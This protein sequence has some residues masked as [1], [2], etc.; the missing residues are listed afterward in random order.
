MRGSPG[1]PGPPPGL[2]SSRATVSHLALVRLAN[3][4]HD[5]RKLL[6]RCELDFDVP[7]A[8]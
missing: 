4:A 8:P 3:E 6:E 5:V 2:Y 1:N 7:V